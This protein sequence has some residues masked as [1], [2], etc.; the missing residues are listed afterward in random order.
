MKKILTLVF[1]CAALA[2]SG[3]ALAQG[4][5]TRTGIENPEKWIN[6]YFAQGKVPPFSFAYEEISSGKFITEWKFSK[7]KVS[8]PK[9]VVA[10]TVT[11]TDPT[12]VLRVICDVKGYSDTKAVE[13]SLTFKN[14]S[15]YN[16]SKI[17]VIRVADYKV[18]EPS[19]SGF[20]ARWTTGFNGSKDDFTTC[21][22][23]LRAGVL[24]EFTPEKGLSSTGGALP[25]F[26]V[27]SREADAGVVMAIGWTGRWNAR[28][29]GVTSLEYRMFAGLEKA[30][31]YLKPGEEARTPLVATIFWKGSDAADGQ[32]ALRRFILAHH[33]PRV[34]GSLW[35][36]YVGG[37]DF[38]SPAPC[39]GTACLTEDLAMAAVKRYKQLSLF[40]DVFLME[41]GWNPAPGDWR[42]DGDLFPD[43]L[44]TLSGLI[45]SY[46][47]KLMLSMDVEN[48]DKATALAKDHADY[49]LLGG[50][51]YQ[52]IF[53]FSQPKAVDWLCKYIG[54]MMEREG[55]DG[56]LC[57]FTGDLA[58][59]WD[60]ADGV[61]RAGLTEIKY[62]TGLY[63]FWDY[64]LKRFPGC[65]LDC[66]AS[67]ARVDLEVLSR[68][69]IVGSG[70]ESSPEMAQ[71][72]HYALNQ[73]IPLLCSVAPDADPYDCRS[74]LG[75]V[76]SYDFGL[77]SRGLSGEQMQE[78]LKEYKA[79]RECLLG[80]YYPLSG[81]VA[82]RH[83]DRWIV[84][85]YH[86]PATGGGILLAFRRSLAEN[87][88]FAAAFRGLD[89]DAGYELYD[90][91]SQERVTVRGADLAKGYRLR[92]D[93]T[94]ESA[95]VS[96]RLK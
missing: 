14:I 77:F 86:N 44:G 33:S 59:F 12:N 81:M 70:R 46:G 26:N 50:K 21:E 36:P 4:V 60:L 19:A 18:S 2:F 85:Q 15:R 35:A 67:L 8:S 34:N 71:C 20:T 90:F 66:S 38:G 89:P 92:I 91:D 84:Q 69:A 37:F 80:D 16:T 93:D 63:R 64:I 82:Q 31:F 61:D 68:S 27:E 5:I 41:K 3:R 54:D 48:I 30:N 58:H 24:M 83:D 75:G 42:F 96:Y 43:G 39:Q 53:D 1:V 45:H 25:F 76:F 87:V 6:T 95:L 29:T 57:D 65:A 17:A 13:W 79:V 40:P 55:V 7:K 94:R 73:Y 23:D 62:V 11:W 56:L 51:K 49:M 72:R 88:T 78:R 52:Y 9:G 10:Y 22:K 32:N 28:L 74:R 47:G